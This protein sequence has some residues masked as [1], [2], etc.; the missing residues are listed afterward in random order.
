MAG[1]AASSPKKQFLLSSGV[2]AVSGTLDVYLAGTTTRSN[3][4][5]DSSLTTLNTNP[6][7]LDSRGECLL[8][9]DGDLSYRF[10]LKNAAGVQQWDVDNIQGPTGAAALVN[11]LQ[12]GTGATTRTV[13]SKLRDVVSIADFGAATTKTAAQNKTAIQAALDSGAKAVF[14]PS[15]TFECASGLTM[16]NV[17]GFVLYGEGP[18]SVLQM[19]ATASALIKW[20]TAAIVYNEQTIRGIG[21][22]GTNGAGHCIDTSGA[23]GLTIEN[24]YITDVPVAKTGIYINGAAATQVHDIRINGLQIYSN[25][26]GH[27]G[28]RFGPLAADSTVSDFIMN[29]N[30]LV[31]YCLYFDS[32][33]IAVEVYNSHPYNAKIN[34]MKV[35]GDTRACGFHGVVFDNAVQDVVNAVTLTNSMFTNCYFQAIPSGYIGVNLSSTSQGISFFA[36]RWQCTAGALS[37]VKGDATSN[38]IQAHGGTITVSTDYTTPFDFAGDNCWARGIGGVAPLGLQ[39]NL[40]GAT[41]SAQAQNTTQYLGANG[42]QSTANAT[43]FLAPH[44]CT[45]KTIYIAVTDTPAAGQNYVFQLNVNGSDVGSTLTVSNGQFGGTLTTNYD[46][47]EFDALT[48]KSVFSATSGASFVRYMLRCTA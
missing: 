30:F 48:V 40:Q 36:C 25:T 7:V 21:I 31:D 22:T 2:P 43:N 18:S 14:I 38:T 17:F 23:G 44:D 16:P 8:W 15:G 10:V 5:Q 45:I 1:V 41:S 29:G 4:W 27:S 20:S 34:V 12:S 6:I 24:V 35:A 32:G 19:D 42:G 3:T 9:L 33:V 28:V 13:Q 11:F 39:F 26:A 47:S 37:A 46:V